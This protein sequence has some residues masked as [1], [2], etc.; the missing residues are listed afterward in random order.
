[1][2]PTNTLAHSL[3]CARTHKHNLLKRYIALREFVDNF[4][5]KDARKQALMG[6]GHLFVK[7][8]ALMVRKDMLD[9]Y[10]HWLAP[11]R[12]AR[13]EWKTDGGP[14]LRLQV[15]QVSWSVCLLVGLFVFCSLVV[16]QTLS[17][18]RKHSSTLGVS[19]SCIFTWCALQYNARMCAVERCVRAVSKMLPAVVRCIRTPHST[20]QSVSQS[21]SVY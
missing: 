13:K 12:D 17:V 6:L 19:L 1:L 20:H 15:L 7:H 10:R 11:A 16:E 14:A 8:P 3:T 21:V 9:V 5:D 4:G 2:R 18:S